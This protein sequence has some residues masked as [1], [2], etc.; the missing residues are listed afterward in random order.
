MSAPPLADRLIAAIRDG[1]ATSAAAAEMTGINVNT[2]RVVVCTLAARGT[3]RWT[4]R[5]AERQ[6]GRV[7]RLARVYEVVGEAGD[8]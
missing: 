3:L 7:G 2:A 1:A 4:G 5:L 6:N 8:V